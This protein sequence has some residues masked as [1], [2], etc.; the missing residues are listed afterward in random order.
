[1]VS[2]VSV[3]GVFFSVLAVAITIIPGKETDQTGKSR[4]C[5]WANCVPNVCEKKIFSV[6]GVARTDK[7]GG[8]CGQQ[9]SWGGR[10]MCRVDSVDMPCTVPA[11]EPVASGHVGQSSIQRH[12]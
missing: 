1:L 3:M 11:S 9:R 8:L 10:R 2:D 6:G 4:V 7:S 12:S 5:G